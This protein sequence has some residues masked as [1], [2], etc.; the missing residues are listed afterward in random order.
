VRKGDSNSGRKFHY[1]SNTCKWDSPPCEK[2]VTTQVEKSTILATL[3]N[4]TFLRVKR[5]SNSGRKSHYPSNTCK[6]DSSPC[7]KG[8]TTHVEYPL[9]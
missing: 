5:S 9:S 6:W 8:V 7:E 3:V 1:P 2:G 4:R